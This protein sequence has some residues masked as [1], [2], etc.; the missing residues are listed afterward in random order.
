MIRDFSTGNTPALRSTAQ[1]WLTGEHGDPAPVRPAATVMIVR[2]AAGQEAV[3]GSPVEVFLLRRVASMA[4]A[5]ST[6]VFPG[7]GV[8]S[9]DGVALPWAGPGVFEWSVRLGADEDSTRMLVVAAVREVFEECGVLFASTT[10]DGPLVDVSSPEWQQVRAGLVARELSLSDVLL[11]HGLCLRTDLLRA[12]AHWVTPVF[13]P[14]RFDTRFFVALMPEGRA[15]D[16]DT[17][18]AD[19]SGWFDPAAVLADYADGRAI[20]LPPTL[21]CLED[22]TRAHSAADFFEH[23]PVIRRIMPELVVDETGDAVMRVDFAGTKAPRG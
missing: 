5:P 2:D 21:V 7:G 4:F 6:I 11:Q 15:I 1:A 12:H 9:R 22:L 19:H 18:E 13:E 10:E 20:V 23:E 14:R 16:G 3:G 17:S 8:D